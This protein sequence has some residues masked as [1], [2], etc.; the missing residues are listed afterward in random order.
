MPPAG[1]C[2]WN[3]ADSSAVTQSV[4][5]RAILTKAANG[6]DGE[7]QITQDRRLTPAN[8]R[9]LWAMGDLAAGSG[10]SGEAWLKGAP[11]QDAAL[12]IVRLGGFKASERRRVDEKPSEEL[13]CREVAEVGQR[14]TVCLPPRRTSEITQIVGQM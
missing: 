5:Q 9:T 14:L 12:R 3:R 10:E 13:G 2:W 11:F 8:R 6:I 4:H 7:P 1:A